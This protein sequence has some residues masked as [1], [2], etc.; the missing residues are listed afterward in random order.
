MRAELLARLL[1]PPVT[2]RWRDIGHVD[3]RCGELLPTLPTLTRLKQSYLQETAHADFLPELPLLRVLTLDCNFGQ[4]WCIPADALLASLVRCIGVTELNINCGFNSAHFSA[5][6]AKLPLKKL[7]IRGGELETL[8]CFSADP[9]TESLEELFISD[10]NLP[11]SELSHLYVLRRLRSL[12]LDRCFSSLLPDAI[13]DSLSPPT[14][15]LPSLTLLFHQW[16]MPGKKRQSAHRHGPSF[17]WMQL[18]R[19]Q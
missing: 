10:L 11:P 7:T 4:A 19:T 3:A 6:F 9:I 18:R 16:Q 8:A 1:Q 15:I 5:L 13:L 12:S 14:P 2:V 17:E